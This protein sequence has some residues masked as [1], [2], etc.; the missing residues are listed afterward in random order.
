MIDELYVRGVGGIKSAGL[1]FSGD[2]IVITGESGAGKSSLVRAFEFVSG[3]RAQTAAIHAGFD[4]ASVEA[5]W[6]VDVS[7]ERLITKRFISRLGKGK[8]LIHGE[9]A[10]VAQLLEKSERLIEIQSQ[11]AQLNLLDPARQLAL[12]DS[13]GG[14]LLIG[15]RERL[16]ELFPRMLSAEKEILDIKKRRRMLEAEMEDAP[17]RVRVIKS[18][19]LY[20]GCEAEWD[21]ELASAEK[22]IEEAGRYSEMLERIEGGLDGEG[23]TDQVSSLLRDLYAISPESSRA[24]WAE[25]GEEALSCLQELFAS[26]K[27]ELG[28]T[29]RDELEARL[30]RIE[31]KVGALRKVKRETG[32]R[33]ADDLLAYVSHVEQT[34][35]WLGESRSSLEEKQAAAAQTRAEAGA[36]A[37]K[38]RTLRERAAAD[39]EAKVNRHLADLAMD[40]SRF[41]V[42]IVRHDKVR[43]SGA[44]SAVFTLAWDGASAGPVSKVAS[45]GELSRILIAIQASLASQDNG[46][47]GHLPGALVFDEVEAGLGGR[48]ALLA[49]EKLRELSKG[50]RVILITHEAAIAAMASQHFVVRRTGDETEVFEISG[51]ERAREI[52]RMLSGSESSEALGHARAL[53]RQNGPQ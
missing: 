10:T 38:L 14:P 31:A 22:Q 8:C 27:S 37:R 12:V 35:K 48:T 51:E 1:S 21:A 53:L 52:A 46:S 15:T 2:F 28:M 29:A 50:C 32:I 18:L 25:L 34:M 26:A 19:S 47:N 13:C 23:L 24:R 42:E 30:D 11:F 17:Q 7:G 40:G 4:E 6:D 41:S 33:S 16:A 44:E 3:R 39:F 36:L 20:Q 45:G 5:V 43:A 49:G 9:P